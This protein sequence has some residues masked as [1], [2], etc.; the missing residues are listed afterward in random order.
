MIVR[1]GW[2]LAA[3]AAV[4]PTAPAIAATVPVERGEVQ[5]A[6]GVSIY[7]ERH[8]SGA[9]VV[10]VPNRL[11]MP[12]MSALARPNRTLILYDMRNRGQSGRVEDAS[13]LTVMTDVEDVEALRR[14]FRA[15]RVSLVGYSYLGLMVALYAAQHPDRVERLVQIAPVPRRFGTAYPPDQIADLATLDAAGQA[16]AEAWQAFRAS[17]GPE[18]SQAELCR[19][20]GRFLAYLLVGNPANHSRVPDVCSYEN[21]SYANQMRHLDAHFGDIQRRDFPRDMFT[22]LAVPVLTIHGTLD[23]NAP[24]GS[25]LEWATTFRNGRL[26]TVE[27]A[28]HQLWLDD[29]AV[30]QEIDAFLAGRWPARARAFGRE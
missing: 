18:T 14:H 9:E 4:L 26:I 6:P 16:A 28:A 3:A 22:V 15:E 7:Y 8:G 2:A 30:I 20:Q 1:A 10:L 25:G 17:A 27:G 5:T 23:R 24:Y 21:E 19:V 11:Y 12:E 13:R 29:P